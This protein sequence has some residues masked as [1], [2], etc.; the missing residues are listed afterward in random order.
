AI[1][2]ILKHQ[3]PPLACAVEDGVLTVSTVDDINTNTLTRVYDVRDLARTP[4]QSNAVIADLESHGAPATWRD[5]GGNVGSM[6]IL[7]GQ[8]IVTQTPLNQFDVLDRLH[9]LRVRQLRMTF[10]P[11][12]GIACGGSVLATVM[13]LLIRALLHR[14]R[15]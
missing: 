4:T 7:S 2:A 9:Q 8:L 11:R 1:I 12:A 10:L 3:R 13:L 14:R 15:R 5:H 6:A